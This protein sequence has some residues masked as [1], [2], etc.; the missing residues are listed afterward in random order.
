MPGP[1]FASVVV[2]RLGGGADLPYGRTMKSGRH[3]DS[4]SPAPA[5][6]RDYR[7]GQTR[8]AARRA[9]G[10]DAANEIASLT[11]IFV[12]EHHQSMEMKLGR[13]TI[14][15]GDGSVHEEYLLRRNSHPYLYAAKLARQYQA[16]ALLYQVE[17][18]GWMS[19]RLTAEEVLARAA[20]D[21][22]F[23]DFPG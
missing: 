14:F 3:R 9:R 18:S 23:G 19:E 22:Q 20:L 1:L 4:S 5:V 8:Q 11:L 16:R 12:D 17:V 6:E 7:W 15:N 21:R 10:S 2:R 13:I